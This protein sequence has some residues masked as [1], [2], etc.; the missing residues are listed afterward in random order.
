MNHKNRIGMM[1][2]MLLT[3]VIIFIVLVAYASA[4]EVK[5]YTFQMEGN[6]ALITYDLEGDEPE[7]EVSVSITVQSKTYS[8]SELHLTG[9]YGKVK[10][11]KGKKIYW[12]ILQDFPKGLRAKVDFEV[13]TVDPVFT[14]PTLGAKFVL[15]PA[16]T[17]TMEDHQVTISKPFY[18]QTTEVTQGQWKAVMGSNPSDFKDCGDNCP[19]ENVSWNDAQ[20]FIQ[21]L[22]SMEGGNKYCFPTEAEWEYAARSAGKNETYSGG[23]DIDAVAWYY[24]NSGDKTHPVGQKKPNGLGIYDMS[25]NVW[26]WCQD[27]YGSYPSGSVTDPTGPSSGAD[28]VLRGG[29]WN[30]YARSSRSAVRD[31]YVPGNGD[32]NLG[33][34]LLRTP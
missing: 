4:A 3:T 20:K 10:P 19:V 24:S 9:D 8:A 13:S 33:F 21:K 30:S 15:V 14:S 2:K 11:G 18:M 34:R 16:G 29:S 7:A 12:N 31:G 26:E 27:W 17:F 23:N 6:R 1:T 32:F 22:N 25:G 5:N 28:R